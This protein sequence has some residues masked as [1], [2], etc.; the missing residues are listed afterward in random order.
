MRPAKPD[1]AALAQAAAA[2]T[3]AEGGAA[4][5]AELIC[6]DE[7]WMRGMVGFSLMHSVRSPPAA[8]YRRKLRLIIGTGWVEFYVLNVQVS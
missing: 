2:A 6:G 3:E 5:A 7:P 1:A 8:S 4:A